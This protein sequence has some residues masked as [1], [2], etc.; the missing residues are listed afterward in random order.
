MDQE[1]Y[2]R[3]TLFSCTV[4]LK[5]YATLSILLW[6]Y[7]Y[8]QSNYLMHKKSAQNL[9]GTAGSFYPYSVLLRPG[10]QLHLGRFIHLWAPNVYSLDYVVLYDIIFVIRNLT[11]ALNKNDL[12]I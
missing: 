2:K 4:R 6:V 12:L 11:V 3:C 1:G 5:Q 10:Q 9:V 8:F 7:I